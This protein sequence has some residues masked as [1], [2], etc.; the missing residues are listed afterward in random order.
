MVSDH[1]FFLVRFELKAS[2][3]LGR[4]STTWAIPP[5]I[6]A[7]IIL[8][9]VF[10]FLPKLAWILLFYACLQ[11]WKTD[12]CHHDRLSFVEIWVSQTFL[13]IYLFIYL[14]IASELRTSSF[15]SRW[16]YSCE[17]PA[18]SFW[19]HIF[20]IFLQGPM[21][22]LTYPPVEAIS[23]LLQIQTHSGLFSLSWP[24]TPSWTLSM[25]MNF[26]HDI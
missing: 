3:L 9:I 22:S 21:S 25:T 19:S 24:G 6:F 13:F 17:P 7:L 14:F 12:M 18:P 10:H 20:P 16:D 5:T 8:E 1:T 2:N 23:D 15:P 11:C 26:P 4:H